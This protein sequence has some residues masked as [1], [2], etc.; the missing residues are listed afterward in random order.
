LAGSVIVFLLATKMDRA[1]SALLY[2]VAKTAT[3]QHNTFIQGTAAGN[4][5]I[6][7]VVVRLGGR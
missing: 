4:I 6:P 2:H 5:R 3:I 7:R 1:Q